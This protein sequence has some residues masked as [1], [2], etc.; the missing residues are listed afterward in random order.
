MSNLKTWFLYRCPDCG[1]YFISQLSEH[2]RPDCTSCSKCYD[3]PTCLG[4][5]GGVPEEAE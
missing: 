2:E 3:F 4:I 1:T 5:V